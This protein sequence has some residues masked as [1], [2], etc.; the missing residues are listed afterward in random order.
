[1][2]VPGPQLILSAPPLAALI[3]SLPAPPRTRSLP[4]PPRT[5]SLPLPPRTTSR[6]TAPVIRSLPRPPLTLSRP[7]SP[8]MQSLPPRPLIRSLPSLPRMRSEAAVPLRTFA[9]ASPISRIEQRPVGSGSGSGSGSV[10]RCGSATDVTQPPVA[11]FVAVEDGGVRRLAQRGVRE[12][13]RLGRVQ[14]GGVSRPDLHSVRRI[15]DRPVRDQ[16]LIA[17]RGTALKIVA[18]R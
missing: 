9:S 14:C 13:F 10:P 15:V 3:V 6:P 1:M 4:R 16:H 11:G 8:R 18:G 17:R 2:S 12:R 5:R 7:R